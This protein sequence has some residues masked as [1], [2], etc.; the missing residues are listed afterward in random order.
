MLQES[1]N[2]RESTAYS[3]ECKTDKFRILVVEDSKFFSTVVKKDLVSHGHEVLQAFTLAEAIEYIENEEFDFIILDLILPD[4]EGDEI[5]DSLPKTLRSKVIVLTGDEDLQRRDYIFQSGVLD[6]FSKTSSFSMIMEDIR[7]LMCVVQH[8]SLLNILL[9]DDS[10]FMR[11]TL[12]N[13]IVPKRFNIYEAQDAAKGFEVLK[14]TEIH[15]ILLDYEMPGMDGAE[16]LEQIKKNQ[17]Y[18]NIPIIMLSGT[19]NNDVVARVLKHGASDF[20]K[21]PFVTEELLLKVD[22]HIRAYIN[23]KRI[24]QKELEL[25]ISLKRAKEAEQHKSM[26]LANMSHEIRTPLNAIIGF[27]DLLAEQETDSKKINY[28]STVQGSSKLLLNLIND[29][30]DFSKIDSNKLDINEEVFVVSELFELVASTYEPLMKKKN[31]RFQKI[32]DSNVP[33]YFSSDFLRIKQIINNFLG[34]AIKFTPEN[35]KVIFEIFLTEDKKSIEISVD[36]SGIGIALENHKKVFELFSQAED[37][38]TKKFGGTGLG[39]TISAKLVELLSG[40]IGLE[41]ALGE[42]SRFYFTLPIVNFDE[43]KVIHH[44]FKSTETEGKI[45]FNHHALLVEDHKA[46]QMFMGI[47]LEEM[48][49]TYDIANDGKEAIVKYKD[50]MYEVILMDENMPN[51]TGIEATKHILKYE[52]ANNLNHVPIIALT[53]NALKGDRER[54]IEAGMDE[55]LTKPLDKKKIE[56]TLN[57]LLL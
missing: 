44:K 38:T 19:Q 11:R 45:K 34:N 13:I 26:F 57:K 41:S 43:K 46:N 9:I 16:M 1:D 47:I 10:S 54:F 42:G 2:S 3:F 28:L 48:G 17:K 29:I 30:L 36:D 22:L 56:S 6:Y 5:I 33:K 25:E 37:T 27:V 21:K 53:A 50:N 4:G 52:K 7:E 20:I 14:N 35:G 49:F 15:L 51:M 18:M 40:T 31:I 12:N 32:I 24:K 55:Y 23:H 39:L 8:N